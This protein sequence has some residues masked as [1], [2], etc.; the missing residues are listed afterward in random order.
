MLVEP[1]GSSRHVCGVAAY[2]AERLL[3]VP[4]MDLYFRSVIEGRHD[5]RPE[6]VPEYEE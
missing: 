1:E 3:V 6:T 2:T 5:C 4:A